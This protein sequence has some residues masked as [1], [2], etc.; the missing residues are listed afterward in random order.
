MNSDIFLILFIIFVFMMTL[1]PLLLR[2]FGIPSVIAL[3][4]AGMIIG[5]NC[6]NVVHNF[7][8]MLS[9]LVKSPA[10]AE[11]N[12]NAL[13]TALGSLGLVFLMALAGMEA[14]FKLIDSAKKPVIALSILT[15]AVP[16]ITGYFVYAYFCPD[17]FPGKLLYASLFASH[18]VGIVFPVIRE[19]K[20]SKTKFGAAVLISTVITDVASI[21]LLAVAVQMKKQEL[22]ILRSG[23]GTLSVFDY[24]NPAVFGSWFTPLFL[25]IVLA[26]LVAAVFA[27]MFIG[28]RIVKLVGDQEDLLITFLLLVILCTVLAG[29]FL[30]INLIVE[31]LLP[32]SPF[33]PSCVRKGSRARL[34]SNLKG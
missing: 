31:P 9:F 18:S 32:G 27:V 24:I 7:S 16:A 21:I 33:P 13:I 4:I 8:E 30:G 15:F 5:P 22:G 19:L 3:L 1:L 2:K 12:F 20:L 26:F 11:Q 25:L 34:S 10:Q 28:K 6:L 23:A 17:D 29:E 14:D